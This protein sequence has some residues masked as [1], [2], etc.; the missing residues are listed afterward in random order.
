MSIIID[1]K[2]EVKQS[3]DLGRLEAM[4]GTLIGQRCLKVELSYG[5]E[6]MLHL[7]TPMPYSSPKL[8]DEAKG[9][10]IIGTRAS[11]WN[12]LLSKP[13]LLIASDVRAAAVAE[14]GKPQ[15]AAPEEVEKKAEPLIGRTVIAV[16][17]E[18]LPPGGPSA[19][20][21]GLTLEFGDG[22]RFVVIPDDH[23]DDGTPLADWELFTPY[24]MYLA[25]GPGP[26]W[27]YAR[28][29]VLKTAE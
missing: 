21:V 25:C 3:S 15:E 14:N 26:V 28:S 29:D 19:G 11:R 9:S 8:A 1:L 22:S 12:L 18:R 16:K 13:P 20:G 7:G 2:S 5:E 23:A 6:L 4:L 10:W 17:P 24:D 27:S